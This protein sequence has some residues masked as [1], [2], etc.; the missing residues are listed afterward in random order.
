MTV[1]WHSDVRVDGV[2]SPGW[3]AISYEA[4]R[5]A[6][7]CCRGSVR[8]CR[9]SEPALLVRTNASI[10]DRH[11]AAIDPL[12]GQQRVDRKT[13][14]EVTIR[15]KAWRLFNFSPLLLLSVERNR[16]NIGYYTYKKANFSVGLE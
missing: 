16:S 12:F 5:E 6:R 3:T 7:V 9:L 10:G 1:R 13:W 14:G 15:S 4:G 2:K 8:A 11:Y